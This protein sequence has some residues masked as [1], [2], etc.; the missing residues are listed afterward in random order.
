MP[1]PFGT[2]IS[3]KNFLCPVRAFSRKTLIDKM[4]IRDSTCCSRAAW[5]ARYSQNSSHI[6]G[7][8]FI[9]SAPV[10][11]TAHIGPAL[12]FLY[13]YDWFVGFFSAVIV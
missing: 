13:D 11:A 6:V 9:A 7:C 3:L 2:Q 1:G 4:C 10:L 5:K 12:H 8:C